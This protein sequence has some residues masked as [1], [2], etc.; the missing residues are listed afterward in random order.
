M[1]NCDISRG[2]EPREKFYYRDIKEVRIRYI[3][4]FEAHL[5]SRRA[6]NTWIRL[7]IRDSK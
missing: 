6:K 2:R 4:L 1:K 7:D 3:I 5:R